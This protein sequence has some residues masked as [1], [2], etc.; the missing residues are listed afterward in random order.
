MM[1]CQV[2]HP[3]LFGMLVSLWNRLRTSVQGVAR[4]CDVFQFMIDLQ[5]SRTLAMSQDQ[6]AATRKIKRSALR[7]DRLCTLRLRSRESPFR[8]QGTQLK[9]PCEYDLTHRRNPLLRFATTPTQRLPQEP[10]KSMHADRVSSSSFVALQVVLD[11]ILRKLPEFKNL[12]ILFST[13]LKLGVYL[14]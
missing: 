6:P 11:V 14:S 13:I 4:F 9:S 8:K 10:P 5:R 2:V 1:R 12:P 7:N 3:G